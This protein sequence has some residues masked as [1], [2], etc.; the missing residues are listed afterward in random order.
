MPI[1]TT[2]QIG[3]KADAYDAIVIGSGVS[4]GWAAKE[5][6]EKGLKTLVLERG[7]PVEHRKDYITEHKAPWEFD[8]RGQLTQEE[9]KEYS[10]AVRIGYLDKTALHF[11]SKDSESPYVEEK[12]FVWARGYQVGGKS[13][14]WGRYTFRISDLDFEAN[15]KEGVGVDWPIRY[16]DIA[17][18]YDYVEQFAG[19]SGEKLGL[20][21]LPDGNFQKPM[22]LNVV[23]KHLRKRIRE[24][25][26]ERYLTIARAA[27]LTEPIGER[28]PCHYC[29][30]CWRGCSTGSYFSS[31]SSTLPAAAATGNL[32]IRPFS[33]VHSIIY[34]PETRKASGV[35]VIDSETKE[36]IEFKA[37]V[38]FVCA[39]AMASTQ[40]LLNSKSEE[41]PDGIGN[42]SRVLGHY[43]MDHHLGMDVN[44]TVPGFLDRTTRGNRPIGFYIP[45]YRN[46]GG[47][48]DMP[49]FSRG[50]GF[51][52]AAYREG[53]SKA[54]GMEGFGADFKNKIKEAG[55]WRV[56]MWGFGETLP[57]YDNHARLHP[58]ETDEFGIPKMVF[59]AEIKD[60]EK[61]MRQ[62]CLDSMAEMLENIGCTNIT[63]E[64]NAAGA[65]PG[66]GIHEMGTA[67]MGRDP[68]TSFLNGN[69]QAH[70]VPNLFVTDGACMTSSPCQNPSITY[71]ALTARA[72]DFAVKQL[73][74]GNL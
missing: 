8:L 48:S 34:D 6:T 43:L 22:E 66:F 53:W 17:P 16:K 70:E 73:K 30:P 72:A 55:E 3:E 28:A 63:A 7:R 20:D 60:N 61:R 24:L 41:F 44:A 65:V 42:T 12:P 1:N 74:S 36:T 29:G 9:K 11:F 15:Q 2:F 57:Y 52:G 45:R 67:R 38:I 18:W 56:G 69:N 58:T 39:S 59:N 21:Y 54:F 31:L 68:K 32:T 37:K 5:L 35:R 40:I 26:P 10:Q 33:V 4:G 19:I 50:Y 62:D 27:V 23:E 46:I 13:I 64:D 14:T 71:M 47:A 25:Y 51:E 49:D